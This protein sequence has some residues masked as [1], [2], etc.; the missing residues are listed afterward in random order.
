MASPA[1]SE[2]VLYYRTRGHLL[3]IGK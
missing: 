3:A 2:N 1:V